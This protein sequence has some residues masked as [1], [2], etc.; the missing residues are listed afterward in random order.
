M[1]LVGNTH[2]VPGSCA[3]IYPAQNERGDQVNWKVPWN[4]FKGVK[5]LKVNAGCFLRAHLGGKK[6]FQVNVI[7]TLE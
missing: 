5:R 6:T 1:F 4:A 3:T 2:Y 7:N